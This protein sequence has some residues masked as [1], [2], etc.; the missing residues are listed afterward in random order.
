MKYSEPDKEIAGRAH[1]VKE[2]Y[3]GSKEIDALK[4]FEKYVN[5]EILW[6]NQNNVCVGCYVG[7]FFSCVIATDH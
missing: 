3:L 1:D 2:L 7:L 6:L 5:V 4:G